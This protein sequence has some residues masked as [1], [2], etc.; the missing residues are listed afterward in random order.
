M[1]GRHV[2]VRV[3]A[4]DI[5]SHAMLPPQ[6]YWYPRVLEGMEEGGGGVCVC[7]GGGGR[8]GWGGGRGDRLYRVAE[9]IQTSS[10]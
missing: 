5:L 2:Y 6:S 7:V 1:H 4:T 8:W 9:G 10:D 3:S